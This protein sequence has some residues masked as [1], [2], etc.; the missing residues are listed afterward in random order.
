MMSSNPYSTHSQVTIFSS[1]SN[2]I[3][4][5][6]NNN[7]AC[8]I[9]SLFP[10]FRLEKKICKCNVNYNILLAPLGIVY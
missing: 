5:N 4:N 7:N 10:I 1:N 6:N 9:F 8:S 3:N 2:N